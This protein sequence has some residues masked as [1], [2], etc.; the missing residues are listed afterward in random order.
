MLARMGPENQETAGQQPSQQP[1]D[2]AIHQ[3][4]DQPS[5]HLELSDETFVAAD[6]AIV[7]EV[8]ADPLRWRAWWPDLSLELTRD[9]GLKGCQ[10][11]LTGSVSGTAEIYLEPWQDGTVVHLFLRL[12]VP[13]AAAR[14]PDRLLSDRTLS[15]KRTVTRL[16]DELEDGRAPGTRGRRPAD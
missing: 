1:A 12:A 8:V 10:W 2:Q 4:A 5:V 11:V 6:R 9:R 7:A 15:W 16:K 14:R 13:V 3:P